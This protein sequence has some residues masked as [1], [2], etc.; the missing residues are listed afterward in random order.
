MPIR[1]IFVRLFFPVYQFEKRRKGA[2]CI[3]IIVVCDMREYVQLQGE[4]LVAEAICQ[5][6]IKLEHIPL[7]AEQ[8][9]HLKMQ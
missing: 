9:A 7:K 4:S 8:I 6:D 5:L 3:K 1:N 2:E